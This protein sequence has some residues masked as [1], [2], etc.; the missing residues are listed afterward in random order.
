LQKKS[1][2]EEHF[3][4]EISEKSQR[5]VKQEAQ[6]ELRVCHTSRGVFWEIIGRKL[7]VSALNP[8]GSY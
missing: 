8:P 1:R 6:K 2:L 5:T 7:C 3:Y 4:G